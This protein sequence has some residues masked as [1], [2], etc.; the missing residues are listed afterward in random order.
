MS[1]P[2]PEAAQM[3][4]SDF[5]ARDPL[6]CAEELVGAELVHGSCSGIVLETEAYR[7]HGDEACH[8]FFR[9]SAR[10]FVAEHSP[11]A[12]YVYLNYGVHWLVNILCIE[13]EAGHCGFVLIRALE[14]REGLD[15]MKRRRGTEKLGNLCSGPG[16][17]TRALAIDGSHH[18][19][20]LTE[21]PEFCLRETDLRPGV[22]ADRRIGISRAKELPWR[23]LA[24]GHPGVSVP[25][26]RAR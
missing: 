9:P 8:L 17:L 26:G 24:E 16:K 20:S 22:V 1:S 11:G 23:F 4:T 13:P 25:M 10:A 2:G 12:A 19:R 18:G 14:P 5:F 3:I 6:I 15:Q 7:E 21:Q